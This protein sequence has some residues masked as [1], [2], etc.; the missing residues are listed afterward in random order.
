MLTLEQKSKDYLRVDHFVA[1]GNEALGIDMEGP[2]VKFDKRGTCGGTAWYAMM[3]LNFNAGLMVDN[4]D[5]FINQVIP[6]EVAHLLKDHKYGHGRGHNS[7]HGI[8]W[9]RVM[10]A[11]GVN[12]DRT[13]SMDVSK[14]AKPKKKY[15][16]VCTGG[17]KEVVLSSVRHNKMQRGTA[18]YT[19]KG[20]SSHKV[21][22]AK[23]LG[24]MSTTE[25]RDHTVPAF[26]KK[27]AMEAKKPATKKAPK[28]G[29]KV[30]QAVTAY[31]AAKAQKPEI[32]R[33]EMI[34]VLAD[35]M[36]CDRHAAAGY[37]QNCKKKVG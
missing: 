24:K 29:T 26:M 37:Y 8:N 14:V 28:A 7:A 21:A 4:W 35:I 19:H 13:H 32:T 5:E 1:L 2:H 27:A 25:A 36:D 33:Q 15:I 10:R 3:E 11:L 12:P 30:A 22:V 20:C 16:Y 6:H 31:Q 23:S 18:N 9:Q 17:K 34:T